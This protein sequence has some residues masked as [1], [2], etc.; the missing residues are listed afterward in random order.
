MKTDQNT[1]L[2][3]YSAHLSLNIK[4]LRLLKGVAQ[5][6]LAL[7]CSIDRTLVSKIERGLGNP[8]LGVLCKISCALG[9]SVCDLLC[10]ALED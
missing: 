2:T 10:P 9:V 4:R 1:V 5:E 8:T 6:R 3:S 7:D